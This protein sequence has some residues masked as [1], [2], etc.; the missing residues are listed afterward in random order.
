MKFKEVAQ[1]FSEVEQVS[2]R[3]AITKLLADI[4]KKKASPNEAAIIAYLSLG[5]LNPV[6]VGTKFN[7]A[8]KSMRKVIALM[9]GLTEETVARHRRKEG[10]FGLVIENSEFIYPPWRQGFNEILPNPLE[11][12]FPIPI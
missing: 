8:E 9:L 3:I 2:S 4:F 11:T 5:N 1:V 12:D 6:Y 10:D 7:F